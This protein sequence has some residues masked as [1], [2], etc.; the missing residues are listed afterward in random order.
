MTARL[1]YF[2]LPKVFLPVLCLIQCSIIY[3][4]QESNPSPISGVYNT[5][6]H[7]CVAMAQSHSGLQETSFSPIR[8][9][10]S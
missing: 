10:P 1:L 2:V 7:I 6:N 9:K 5:V 3:S 8:V 4:V